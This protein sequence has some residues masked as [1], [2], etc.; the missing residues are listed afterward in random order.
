MNYLIGIDDTDN[1]ES[2]GTGY[3][4]RQLANWLEENH[5]AEPRGITRHQLLVDPQIPYTSHNSSACLSVET[6][7][8]ED[9]WEACR[10]YLLR[11][12]AM[13]SDAGLCVGAWDSVNEYVLTF[14]RRAKVEVL[15]MLEAEQTALQSGLRLAGLTGTGGGIIGALAGVG[16]HRTGNDGRFLWLPGLRELKGCYPVS[17]ICMNGHIDRVCTFEGR[18]LTPDTVVDVGEW[19]RPVLHEGKSTLYVEEKN[20][21]WYVVPKDRIKSLSN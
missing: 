3:R 9:T 12:S 21:E 19:I 4:V 2:R 16:L 18:N 20:H 17:K 15:N 10:E 13:G 7:N 5:L 8:V 14:A 1:L 6:D 11:E